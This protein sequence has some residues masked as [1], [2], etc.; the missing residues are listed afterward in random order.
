MDMRLTN[1]VSKDKLRQVQLDTLH[2]L[3][4]AVSQTAGPYGSNTQILKTGYAN[5]Y[6]KDGHDVISDIQFFQ[7][8]EA[9]IQREMKEITRYIVKTVGDGTT[10]AILLSDHIFNELH[11]LEKKSGIRPYLLIRLFQKV[12]NEM[13][14]EIKCHTRECTIE[15]VYNI[16]MTSTNGNEEISKA[17]EEIY[18]KFGR[19]VFIDVAA[20]IDEHHRIKEYDGLTLGKGF[21]SPSFI[22]T[23]DGKCK[24]KNPHIYSFKDNIDDENMVELFKAIIYYNIQQPL[25]NRDYDSY[26]PTVIMVPSV[27]RD[28]QQWLKDIELMMYSADENK[29]PKPPL[30]IIAQA[31][32]VQ[33][34]LDDIV[35]LCGIPEIG[36][37]IN[38][39]IYKKD[40]AEGKAATIENVYKFCGYAEEFISD[41]SNTSFINP[42]KMFETDE[43]GNREYSSVYKGLINFCK[44][45][46]KNAQD[47]MEDANVTGNLKRR[48][49]ALQVNFVEYFIGGVTVT[50]RD[51]VRASVEDAV[52]NCRSA[53]RDGVGYGANYEGLHAILS[54]MKYSNDETKYRIEHKVERA[55]QEAIYNAYKS[56]ILNLYCTSMSEEDA[57]QQCL[58][59]IENKSP[60]NLTTDRYDEKVLTSAMTDIAILESISKVITIMVT[61]NQCLI[62]SPAN[63]VYRDEN[64][65]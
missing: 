62:P 33:Y 56:V 23:P 54:V 24:I 35:T 34:Q 1:I 44:K 29:I 25:R 53:M 46:L 13:I 57:L 41:I 49:N 31:N 58:S 50:D 15:D 43:N 40:V 9:A 8:I 30:C 12:V 39:D 42:A 11:K 18:K 38:P 14:E 28:I 64:G 17:I 59:T 16:C 20:S 22:N 48:L 10:S 52:L 51:S 65:N 27:T 5:T 55:I 36:K 61:A 6:T 4:N 26:V 32:I 7:P 3:A 47:N 63:N 19:N 21:A 45:E 60:L 37:Y 2:T